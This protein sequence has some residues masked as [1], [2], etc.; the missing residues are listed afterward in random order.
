MF[1]LAAREVVD[2]EGAVALCLSSPCVK[3]GQDKSNP[4]LNL[5]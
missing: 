5:L 3:G 2:M 4:L 1:T